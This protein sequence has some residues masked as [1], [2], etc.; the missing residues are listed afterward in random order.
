MEKKLSSEEAQLKMVEME[1]R[2][3]KRRHAAL[4][5]PHREGERVVQLLA[6]LKKKRLNADGAKCVACS[7]SFRKDQLSR[8]HC[9]DHSHLPLPLA[10]IH[11]Q[12]N[13]PVV[14]AVAHRIQCAQSI[15]S[16]C[17]QAHVRSR[18][19]SNQWPIPCAIDCV[20]PVR[21]ELQPHLYCSQ[22]IQMG[23]LALWP[24]LQ[25]EARRVEQRNAER[26]LV[27]RDPHRFALLP[28]EF[29]KSREFFDYFVFVDNA[30]GCAKCDTCGKEQTALRGWE[31]LSVEKFVRDRDTQYLEYFL[32]MW[33]DIYAVRRCPVCRVPIGRLDNA[34]LQVRCAVLD[35]DGKMVGGCG[36]TFC[37]LCCGVLCPNVS[38]YRQRR[39]SKNG[40]MYALAALFALEHDERD[41]P[42][43]VEFNLDVHGS[44]AYGMGL[45]SLAFDLGVAK[46]DPRSSGSVGATSSCPLYL[47]HLV[48]HAEEARNFE[49][50]EQLRLPETV[51]QMTKEVLAKVTE[52]L[53]RERAIGVLVRLA[54]EINRT[55]DRLQIAGVVGYNLVR[56]AMERCESTNPQGRFSYLPREWI[57]L[58][59][60]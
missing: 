58:L 35:K 4:I 7:G 23:D 17:F 48:K 22:L 45:H 1:R 40:E 49:I 5:G 43:V 8:Y 54:D 18:L 11:Q 31:P 59:P 15:C 14:D 60:K 53:D 33:L 38:D 34:C 10:D 9:G 51:D 55:S 37:Y 32:D 3:L 28:C 56:R 24:K 2:A 41:A 44:N 16:D 42:S 12:K 13:H 50:V 47:Q 39:A 46:F 19:A 36:T 26:A 25:E 29:C 27:R 57:K 21:T 6:S 20:K 30:K 52:C